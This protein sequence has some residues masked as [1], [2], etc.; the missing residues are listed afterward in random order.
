ME[1]GR[2]SWNDPKFRYG[3]AERAEDAEQD[4]REDHEQKV[5][6]PGEGALARAAS[7]LSSAVSASFAF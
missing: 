6:L 5:H 3:N 4:T 1:G 2:Q 7:I